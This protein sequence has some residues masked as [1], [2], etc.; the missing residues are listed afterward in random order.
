MFSNNPFYFYQ[1]TNQTDG[2]RFGERER[3]SNTFWAMGM[4]EVYSI[5]I[6]ASKFSHCTNYRKMKNIDRLNE[7]MDR[8]VDYR[9]CLFYF[10]L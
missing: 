9:I 6:F 10:V 2:L 4:N 7:R 8:W 1:R 3:Q 5:L